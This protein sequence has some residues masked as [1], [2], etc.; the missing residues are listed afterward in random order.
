MFPRPQILLFASVLCALLAAGSSTNLAHAQCCCHGSM[1]RGGSMSNPGALQL[2]MQQQLLQQRYLHGIQQQMLQAKMLEGQ[3]RELA[4]QDMVAIKAALKSP[5]AEKRWAAAL[6]AVEHGP[7]LTDGI[8][9]LLTDDNPFVRQAAR[10]ALVHLSTTMRERERMAGRG[11][12]I[13]FGPA[14]AANRASQKI[15]ARNWR[16]WFDRQQAKTANLKTT[17]ASRKKLR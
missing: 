14:P 9:T 1:G 8:L 17:T 10:H 15:A 16:S 3:V 11:R 6:A 13:D 4:G 2:L 12:R 5:L 7:A